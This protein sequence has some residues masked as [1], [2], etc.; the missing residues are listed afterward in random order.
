MHAGFGL[1]RIH[2]LPTGRSRE[3]VVR[4]A[5]EAGFR[6]FDLAP[7]YGDGLCEKELGRI[8]GTERSRVRI[9]T[10]FGIPFRPI[11]ELPG[12][13]Y[14]AIRAVAKVLSTSFGARYGERN[15]GPAELAT[16]LENSLRRLRTDYIDL[17]LVHEP[18]TVDE[19]RSIDTS[20]S[21]L[22][23]QQRIGK[24]RE[25]GVS[26]EV[27]VLLEAEEQGLVPAGAVRMV[28][29][30][31]RTL[32]L[33]RAWF[34]ERRVFVFNVVK[35]LRQSLG[36]GRIESRKLVEAVA[37]LVPESTPIFA[38]HDLNEIR[39]LGSAIASMGE[40]NQEIPA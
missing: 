38:S 33:P 40:S 7:A 8:L 35:H 20:W 24:I 28:P 26:A 21:E 1:G 25:F 13:L 17:M 31:T 37:Q 16:S 11:G 34:R 14:F 4:T 32:E 3:Q 5:I 12:A 6:H 18:R 23:R 27:E 10:K 2:H 30:C 19:F 39:R 29:L 22:E 9:A 36:P 15:F